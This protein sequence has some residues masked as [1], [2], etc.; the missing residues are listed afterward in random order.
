MDDEKSVFGHNPVWVVRRSVFALYKRK[1]WLLPP[2]GNNIVI[3]CAA[4]ATDS[5]GV[6]FKMLET[7]GALLGA[8]QLED[9]SF[10]TVVFTRRW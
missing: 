7:L 3:R 1:I 5:V 4:R 6:T 9:G 2:D 10:E 8:F